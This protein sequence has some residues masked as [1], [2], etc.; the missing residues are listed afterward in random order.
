MAFTQDNVRDSV[1]AQLQ[2]D[3]GFV[4]KSVEFDVVIADALR[5]MN[6]DV[7]EV[8][9]KDITGDGT[10]NLGLPTEFKKGFSDV[11]SVE[12][13]IDNIPPLFLTRYDSWLIYEDP[14]ASPDMRLI[15]PTTTPTSSDTVR[16]RIKTPWTIPRLTDNMFEALVNLILVKLYRALASKMAQGM[17]PTIEAD[18]VDRGSL[19][20]NYLFLAERAQTN[21]KKLTGLSEDVIA[22]H[23]VRDYD[24]R[25]SH[26]EVMFWRTERMR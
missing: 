21:Y 4:Q 24:I 10:Q 1:N 9:P 20:S 23:V 5:E 2:D 11:E 13:P 6:R 14:T 7:P 16:V 22:A 26:G 17:D 19:G 3:A 12:F 25:Y 8:V 15:L 18:T